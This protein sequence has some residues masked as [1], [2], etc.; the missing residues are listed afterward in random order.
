M[1]KWKSSRMLTTPRIKSEDC[2]HFLFSK[3]PCS[4]REGNP[5]RCTLN[6]I[7]KYRWPKIIA[8]DLTQWC[9]K[10]VWIFFRRL[11][12]YSG[13]SS[14]FSLFPLPLLSSPCLSFVVLRRALLETLHVFVIYLYLFLFV[15]C[16]IIWVY[17]TRYYCLC[18]VCQ[19]CYQWYLTRWT[20]QNE[21]EPFYMLWNQYNPKV[22]FEII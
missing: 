1:R 20:F 10:W 9:H 8:R 19:Y 3:C 7:R 2:R 5:S 13:K 18:I 6:W 22:S 11:G 21:T 4:R 17:H 12:S 16:N 15:L 14:S